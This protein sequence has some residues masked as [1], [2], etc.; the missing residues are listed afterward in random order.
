MDLYI[1]VYKKLQYSSEVL[2][3]RALPVKG[4]LIVKSGD[5]VVP[6]T[7]IGHA[8][9]SKESFLLDP[10]IRLA[11]SIE[12]RP[13]VYEGEKIGTARF[14]KVTA[15]Y[16]G[17]ISEKNGVYTFHQEKKDTWLLS[18]VWGTVAEN[19]G[20]LA[21]KIKTQ[22][23]DINF[24]AYSQKVLMG[25]LIVFP[26]PKEGD[27]LEYLEK[28]STNVSGKILYVGHHISTEFYEKSVELGVAGL[29]AGS[30]DRRLYSYSKS[31]HTAVCITTG[32]GKFETP[33]FIFDFLKTISNRHVFLDGSKG[34]L[35]VPVPFENNFKSTPSDSSLRLVEKG[36]SVLI[37]DKLHFGQTGE[38]E[39]VQ[40]E[41]IYV[42]LNR[43]QELVEAKVPNI[44]ALI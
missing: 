37:F 7:K 33:K 11:K 41:I 19:V 22:T 15:P 24:V 28:F 1:P 39:K 38:V 29:V 32:F 27:D 18:G 17:F 40:D 8:K 44:F 20:N 14:S 13:F 34:Y 5:K 21:V 16:S 35:R 25:E 10:K 6:F 2:L 36:L 3:E 31:C 12:E 26:N 42:R 23:V 30:V 43:S 9:I 4:E